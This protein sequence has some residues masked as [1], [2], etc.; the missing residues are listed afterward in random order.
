MNRRIIKQAIFLA[1]IPL[2]TT[3][4]TFMAWGSRFLM[5]S[6]LLLGTAVQVAAVQLCKQDICRLV[7]P[8]DDMLR[9]IGA[10]HLPIPYEPG[11]YQI[12]A[13]AAELCT[14][15]SVPAP[16]LALL[17][18]AFP[19]EYTVSVLNGLVY[20]GPNYTFLLL[21]LTAVIVSALSYCLWTYLEQARVVCNEP[22]ENR[23]YLLN[24]FADAMEKRENV[25]RLLAVSRTRRRPAFHQI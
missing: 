17:A 24:G 3:L 22:G 11:K 13:R 1:V 4:L 12:D 6:A 21:A 16:L 7:H 9:Q 20:T 19:K 8:T 5:L 14:W 25:D 10:Q 18:A 23:R 15:L 2:A